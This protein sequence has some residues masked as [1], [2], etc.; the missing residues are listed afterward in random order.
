[1][2]KYRAK[3]LPCYQQFMTSRQKQVLERSFQIMRRRPDIMRWYKDDPALLHCSWFADVGS[4]D[5]DHIHTLARSLARNSDSDGSSSDNRTIRYGI[6][7]SPFQLEQRL[8]ASVLA[9]N[10]ET[11]PK[12]LRQRAPSALI[13]DAL[14]EAGYTGADLLLLFRRPIPHPEH[15][16][17]LS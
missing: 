17:R 6:F 7:I 9:W 13:A 16:I 12:L 3:A 14:E 5:E 2:N 10:D 4:E 11:V 15:W 1:M 8:P